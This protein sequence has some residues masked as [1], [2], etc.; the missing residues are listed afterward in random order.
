VYSTE[1]IFIHSFSIKRRFGE[2]LKVLLV[3]PQVFKNKTSSL[4]IPLEKYG[5]L[6]TNYI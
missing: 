5:H 3:V 2:L 6:K 4:I 1:F